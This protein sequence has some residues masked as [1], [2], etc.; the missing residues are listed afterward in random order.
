[1]FKHR[2]LNVTIQNPHWILFLPMV[3][4]SNSVW[5]SFDRNIIVQQKRCPNF[6]PLIAVVIRNHIEVFF[7]RM[8]ILIYYCFLFWLNRNRLKT[9][10]T[11][12]KKISAFRHSD[13]DLWPSCKT[14]NRGLVISMSNS[15]YTFVKVWHI[16]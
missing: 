4:F 6:S 3:S 13:I 10:T 7:S 9:K 8:H 15:Q 16:I 2:S 1:M 12:P 11:F 14:I 5:Q